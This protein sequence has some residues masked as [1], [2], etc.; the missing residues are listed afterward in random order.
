MTRRK[1]PSR[2]K[3]ASVVLQGVDTITCHLC[4]KTFNTPKCLPCLHAFCE[5]CLFK[6][7]VSK[8]TIHASKS[9]FKCPTCG[10]E[11]EPP[12]GWTINN[13]TKWASL[14]PDDHLIQS[15]IDRDKIQKMSKMC[16][17]CQVNSNLRRAEYWCRLCCEGYCSA[18]KAV[19][20]SMKITKRHEVVPVHHV[21]KNPSLINPHEPCRKHPDEY[22]RLFCIDHD[23][24]CCALC[25]M[26]DHRNCDNITDLYD[27]AKHVKSKQEY[28]KHTKFLRKSV[29]EIQTFESHI[30]KNIME[31]TE[32]R[33]Q[34]EK[35]A[36]AFVDRICERMKGLLNEYKTKLGDIHTKAV[37]E[38]TEGK[39]EAT[40]EHIFL[41][42][43]LNRLEYKFLSDEQVFLHL[44]RAMAKHS[45]IT[46]KRPTTEQKR[47]FRKTLKHDEKPSVYDLMRKCLNIDS[48]G[49]V[50]VVDMDNDM[51]VKSKLP[52]RTNGLSAVDL[53][54]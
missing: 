27:A 11:A 22:I 9:S 47:V 19:H 2:W 12:V 8:V 39:E 34:L 4:K 3:E 29:N 15:C 28:E 54:L 32:K 14:F 5:L 31:L 10:I 46:E 52:S 45:E 6:W 42:N 24:P 37:E 21:L 40:G 48:L 44:K 49:D 23:T 13:V 36:E 20:G 38:L 18:C 41:S 16:D 25:S 35:S 51:N 7:I 1:K 43:V 26:V 50:T 30:D 33:A 17:I 53:T